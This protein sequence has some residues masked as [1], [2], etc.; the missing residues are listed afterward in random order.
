M[1]VMINGAFGAGK[2]VTAQALNQHL[3][4][5][6]IFDPE[7]VG[8]ML[9]NITYPTGL[10]PAGDFQDIALWPSMV[11]TVT[12]AL[13]EQYHKHLILPISLP[14]PRY[15]QAIVDGICAFESNFLHFCLIA[16]ATTLEQR[17]RDRDGEAG[18]WA[19]QQISRCLKA[20]EAPEYEE[21]LDTD[22]LPLEDIVHTIF[23]RIHSV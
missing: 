19:R 12:R 9:R 3:P 14:C 4:N 21:K 7:E 15:F 5:S 10:E 23:T 6:V 16:S 8:F 20:F 1:I 11:V 22:A 17:L 18:T 2:T 13:Y